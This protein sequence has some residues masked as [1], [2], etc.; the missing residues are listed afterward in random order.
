MVNNLMSN[1]EIEKKTNI[2]FMK[3]NIKKKNLS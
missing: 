1:D 3:K 2:N